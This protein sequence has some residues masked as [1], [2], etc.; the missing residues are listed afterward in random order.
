METLGERA[1]RA[2]RI[3]REAPLISYDTETS[4]LDWKKN[5]PVGYVICEGT[6][7]IYIPIRHGGGSNLASP[8]C[9]PLISPT[10]GFVLHEFEESLSKA[11]SDR[12]A[13]KYTTIMHNAPFDLHFSA[14]AGVYLGRYCEDTQIN[15]CLIDEFSKSYSLDACAKV[16]GVTAKL[17]D[18]LYQHMAN[19][20]G[21][22]ASRKQMEHYW[23]L[24]G[25]DEISYSY[26]IGDGFTTLELR[27]SQLKIIKE[28][29]LEQIHQLESNLIWTIFKIERRGMRVDETRIAW[30]EEELDKKLQI[31]ESKLP[32]RF[33]VRSGPQMKAL[34]E[35]AGHTDWPTTEKGNP[36]FTE[37]WLK[38]HDTGR[39]VVDIRLLSN[40]KNSFLTPLKE[41]HLYKGRVHTQLHQMRGDEFGTISGRLSSSNPNMQQCPK[42]N[43]ELGRL[44]RSVFI[45]DE[46]MDFWEMDFSQ[47]EP[48]TIAH[49][50]NDVALIKGYNESPF[51]D[52]HT[53]TAE[54]LSVER[55]PTGKRMSMGIMTGM[56]P[57]SLAGHMGWSLAQ[58]TKAYNTWFHEFPGVKEFQDKA[59]RVFRNRGYVKTILGRRCRL[60]DPR[61]EYRAFSRIIQGSGADILKYKLLEIDQ[62]LEDSAQTMKSQLL[63]T[64]HDSI[65]LQCP[66]GADEHI[67]IAQVFGDV[68]KEPFNLRVP[69]VVDMGGGPN[70]AIS[71]YGEEK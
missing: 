45:P 60:D 54:I 47:A 67:K 9:G 50:S 44:F 24:P 65:E 13:K 28:Q 30:V 22:E 41:R 7:S 66:T 57:K 27:E 33:N 63:C 32:P 15:E 43:K 64:I 25:T 10:E 40:L 61:F 19:I 70:W 35:S 56:G 34:M 53:L 52:I 69:F 37:K 55:D 17:G 51:R 48:R 20:F 71:T 3:V 18:E 26:A 62:M 2:L 42:R 5:H 12:Q 6:E 11:F 46:E 1:E 16:H 68:Q 58:A 23:K 36:S 8:R 31:A 4:G 14:N 21:G 39:A 38:T 29:E 49:Y 59:T